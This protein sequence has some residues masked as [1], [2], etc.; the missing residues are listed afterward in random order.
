M[1]QIVYAVRHGLTAWNIEKKFQGHTDLP[2]HPDGKKQAKVN[3][4]RFCQELSF[5]T[6]PINMYC[7]TL[8][9][10]RETLAFFI[11]SCR[12]NIASISYSEQ[13]SEQKFGE[14]ESYTQDQILEKNASILIEWRK[15]PFLTRVPNGESA[16]DVFKRTQNF[17]SAIKFPAL[18]V[19]HNTNLLAIINYYTHKQLPL[20]EPLPQD[21]IY[22]IEI[23]ERK[24]TCTAASA[25]QAS[26]TLL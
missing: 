12:N 2:L 13:I 25:I 18:I 21:V 22:K 5:L 23:P 7:S 1:K 15:N 10:A 26:L 3:A 20:T 14:W 24:N 9:R 8:L 19:T 4:E 17:L 6:S 11:D 16:S